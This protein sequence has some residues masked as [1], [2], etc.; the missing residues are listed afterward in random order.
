MKDLGELIIH[1]CMGD[2]RATL[3]VHSSFH[4]PPSHPASR[5][6]AKAV[7][8]I[9]VWAVATNFAGT[10]KIVAIAYVSKHDC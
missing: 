8:A 4:F 3:F 10:A 6:A 5:A 9:P 1:V 7:I 2:L